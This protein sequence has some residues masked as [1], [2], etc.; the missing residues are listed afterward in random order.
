MGSSAVLSPVPPLGDDQRKD[1]TVTNDI[2]GAKQRHWPGLP[3]ELPSQINGDGFRPG[4]MF[5]YCLRIGAFLQINRLNLVGQ[6]GCY[7]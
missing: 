2:L 7:F 6:T 4:K 3:D 1:P 5:S